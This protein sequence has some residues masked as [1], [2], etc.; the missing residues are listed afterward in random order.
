MEKLIFYLRR[1]GNIINEFCKVVLG[2][3][4]FI[5]TSV[6]VIQV[7]LR[8]FTNNILYWADELSRYLFIWIAMLGSSVASRS[9]L[10][11]GV[12]ILTDAL[13]GKSKK[14]IQIISYICLFVVLTII[15]ISGA[16]QTLKQINQKAITMPFSM[17]WIFI[18]IPVLGV[19]MMYYSLIQF[20]ELIYYGRI[21]RL[22]Y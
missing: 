5:M 19:L 9:L 11:I 16:Q 21:D 17:A 4:I 6:I 18:S 7:F 14:L 2:I 22:H 1:I 12:D 13:K 20:L 10:H 15:I 3:Q 8:L